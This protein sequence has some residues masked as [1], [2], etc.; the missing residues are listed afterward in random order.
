V[1]QSCFDGRRVV[2]SSGGE[3]KDNK[4]FRRRFAAWAKAADSAR[5]VAAISPASLGTAPFGLDQ[6]MDIRGGAKVLA[7]VS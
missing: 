7:G 3:A 2:I 5:F 4:R 1:V 6:I